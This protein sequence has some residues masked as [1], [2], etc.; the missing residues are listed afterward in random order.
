MRTSEAK[1]LPYCC[2]ITQL[3][4]KLLP[5]LIIGLRQGNQINNGTREG[6][7][8]GLVTRYLYTLKSLISA[9][10]RNHRQCGISG[11]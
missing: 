1:T 8:R 7:M 9:N 6:R 5:N 11:K 10:Q 4:I 3:M 2:F